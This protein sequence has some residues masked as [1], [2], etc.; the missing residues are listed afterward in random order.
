MPKIDH[1]IRSN[2]KTIA[3]IIERDGRITV[4]APQNLSRKYIDAFVNQ[5]RTWIDEKQK[6]VRFENRQYGVK[7]FT[8]GEKFDYLGQEYPLVFTNQTS[9]KLIFDGR[10]FCLSK[11]HKDARKAFENWYR[12][13]A[14]KEITR[15]V[16]KFSNQIY[17]DYAKIRISGAR[18]RWGSCSS[19]GTLSFSWRLVMTPPDMI[20]YVVVHELVHLEHPNHSRSFWERTG[21][22]LPDYKMRRSWLKEHAAR[23]NW[24]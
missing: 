2:R 19:L 1:L 11:D 5:K 9:A 7:N 20:D 16:I 18:T 6:Q 15:R 22:I 24:D 23:F 8:P 14:R 12:Q 13:A 17:C 21:E 3:I 10:Q 4:R